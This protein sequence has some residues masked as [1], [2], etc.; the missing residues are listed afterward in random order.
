MIPFITTAR[1]NILNALAFLNTRA[2]E[3]TLVLH[4]PRSGRDEVLPPPHRDRLEPGVDVERLQDVADVVPHSLGAEVKLAGDLFGRAALLQE[5]QHLGLPRRQVRVGRRRRLVLLD[6]QDLSEDAD[7]PPAALER[8][9]ADLDGQPFAIRVDD[10]HL[11]VRAGP[12][13]DEVPGEDL[14]RPARFL[15]RHDGGELAAA[16]VS[17]ALPRG[18]IQPADDPVGI[19]HVGGY[20]DPLN[21]VL[22]FAADGLELGHALTESAPRTAAAQLRGGATAKTAQSARPPVRAMPKPDQ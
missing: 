1:A 22:D 20:A 21:G 15:G 8:N 17:D 7:H 9:R 11:V 13:A 10:H 18:R 14:P 2:E 6:V 3:R 12:R 16:N 5:A 19:D 4:D